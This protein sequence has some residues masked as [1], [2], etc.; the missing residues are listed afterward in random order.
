MTTAKKSILIKGLIGLFLVAAPLGLWGY[1]NYYL[2]SAPLPPPNFSGE[3]QARIKLQDQER[4]RLALIGDCQGSVHVIG[5][6][7]KD[8]MPRADA[9][10]MLGDIVDYGAP[11]FFRQIIVKIQATAPEFPLGYVLGNHDLGAHNS[12]DLFRHYFGADRFWWRFGRN[13]FIGFNNA[14]R[15]RW[16]DE[17]I[18]WLKETLREQ[19]REGDRIY[20]LMHKPPYVNDDLLGMTASHTE[21]LWAVLAPYPNLTIFTG[22]IH[23]HKELDFRGRPLYITGEAGAPQEV[24]PANYSYLL[25]DCSRENCSVSRRDLGHLPRHNYLELKIVQDLYWFWPALAGAGLVFLAIIARKR[26]EGK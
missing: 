13:L 26:K 19:A 7:L 5:V 8:A 2:Y 3:V 4:F 15:G 1:I 20:L 16:V 25:L 17:Q 6:I 18:P 9:G 22:H 11:R 24:D 12:G 14:E 21:K 10:V 23:T